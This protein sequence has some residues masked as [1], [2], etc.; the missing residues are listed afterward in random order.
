MKASILHPYRFA[1]ALA[2]VLL[3]LSAG[4]AAGRTHNRYLRMAQ[5]TLLRA[6]DSLATPDSLAAPDSAALVAQADSLRRKA[7]LDSLDWVFWH[8]IDTLSLPC[9]DSLT[10]AYFDSLAQ[11]LPDTTDIRR[12]M[13][14]NRKEER[15]SLRASRPR[16]LET[17]VVPDSLYYR[18]I[19][20]WTS[21]KRYNELIPQELDT[22]ANSNFYEYPMFKKD[23]S[24]SY[25]GTAGS[26][27]LYHNYFKREEMPDAPMFTPYAGDSDTDETVL[28]FNTKTPYT[29]LGYWG[30]PFANRTMEESNLRLLTTQNISP[31]FNFTLAYRRLGSRGML[32][33][34]S[35]DHR[36]TV[37]VGNYMGKR[38]FA[39]FGTV[40]QR[41]EH[42]ENGGIQDSFWIRDT[43]VEPK[44][45]AVNL[46]D[47]SNTYKRRSWFIHQTLAVPM[48]FFR[49]DRDSLS[50]GEGTMA[51]IGHSAEF[52]TYSKIYTDRIAASDSAGRAFYFNRF[53]LNETESADELSVRNFENRFFLKLQPYASDALL[54][55]INAGLGYQILSTYGFRPQ[56]YLSGPRYQTQH[57]IYVYGGASG[58]LRKYI[59]WKADA[60]YYLAGPRMFDFDIDAS[61]RFSVYPVEQGIHL[62]GKFHTG[63]RTPHPFEQTMSM[64]HHQWQNDFSKVSRSTVEA[65]LS[66]PKWRLD[67]GFG[68]ALTANLL[69]YDTLSVI[70]QYSEAPVSV[71]S[72]WLR[73][74]FTFWRIHLDNQAL[75]Q[76]SSA[77]EVLPLPRLTLNLR[78]YFDI[79]VVKDVMNIQ[80]GV[81]AIANTRWYAPAFA[82]DLGQFYNQTHEK[83]GNAPYFDIF[84]NIQWKQACLYVKYANAFQDWPSSDYFSAYHYI[85]PETGIRFGILWPFY[86]W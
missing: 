72:A 84:A 10:L 57:N 20:V 48:N 67:A 60:D 39:N 38:Y 2:A 36:T 46:T 77:P 83:I 16:V 15:D 7:L 53:Y 75:F 52:T 63:L 31:A 47:A 85:R 24:G 45:I 26:A 4:S 34:E 9:S 66:I 5:D 25:L 13:R 74:D 61:L 65:G 42:G 86:I 6:Q 3:L 44:S 56:D 43:S 71:M 22:T 40:R 28:Q 35:T 14:R 17:F 64:N 11:F 62:S 18:R 79:D 37:I 23:I 41:V 81:N 69:Y 30:T 8:E 29:E 49:R 80:L 55:R 19:L 73:K 32:A 59:A 51:Q 68:Y 21:D 78:W 70:R 58:Q 54:A 82:P 50:L 1:A 27:A 76:L 33:N 12:A